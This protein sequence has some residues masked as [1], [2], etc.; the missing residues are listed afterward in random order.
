[1]VMLN[2]TMSMTVGT[3]LSQNNMANEETLLALFDSLVSL[4]IIAAG[5]YYG[6]FTIPF[7]LAALYALQYFY[8]RT[9]RQMRHLDLEAKSPLYTQFTEMALGAEHIRAFSWGSE[10][11]AQSFQLLEYSQKPYYH[12]FTIQ[13][14]LSLVLDLMVMAIAVILVALALK[15]PHTSSEAAVGLA[16]LSVVN[17]GSSMANVLNAWT[18]LETSLGAIARLRSFCDETPT[19]NSTVSHINPPKEWPSCG[20]V[21]FRGVSAK[22][23]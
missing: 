7:L 2:F 22:Y 21:E 12:M 14:W 19:E 18:R 17:F 23:A 16:L 8:L 6:A 9:S 10:M 15:L 1:M 5:A 13:R 20:R 11:M 4:G 3:L